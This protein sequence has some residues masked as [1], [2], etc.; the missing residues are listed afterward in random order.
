MES[1]CDDCGLALVSAV[2]AAD[3]RNETLVCF[4]GSVQ[5]PWC[6][7]LC[8]PLILSTKA[9]VSDLPIPP[10]LGNFMGSQVILNGFYPVVFP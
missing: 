3:R 7:N 10:Y 6:M 5:C 1:Q 2:T 9:F 8:N 4:A